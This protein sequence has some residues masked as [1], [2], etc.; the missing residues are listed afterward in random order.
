MPPFALIKILTPTPSLGE[1]VLIML[2]FLLVGGLPRNQNKNIF[3][4]INVIYYQ[5]AAI[6]EM[7]FINYPF[8]GV[9]NGVKNLQNFKD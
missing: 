9:V 5:A 4:Q 2:S 7:V 8:K 3:I 6:F 1:A